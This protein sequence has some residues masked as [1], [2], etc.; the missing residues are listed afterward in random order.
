[1]AF[2]HD[3]LAR[4]RP[5]IFHLTARINLSRIRRLRKLES[6]TQLAKQAGRTEVLSERR[7]LHERLIID[8]EPVTLRDQAPLHKGN[9][10]LEASW[11]FDEFLRYLNGRVFFWPGTSSG[12]VIS[13]RRHFARYNAESPV[14]LR[15][16]FADLLVA[17]PGTTPEFCRFNSGS[18]RWHSGN[19]APRGPSTFV[20]ATA[21]TFRAS[22]VVE[23]TVPGE[24]QLPTA[25]F[26]GRHP[27]GP[28]RP[29]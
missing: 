2:T 4:L 21:A 7:R 22:Q 29:L 11:T 8:G 13:G 24:V 27:H 6:A 25:V 3:E 18:P 15:L 1:M 19:P 9:M 5:Y 26:V 20:N 16:S 28:W 17:N 23:I 10:K 14:I 12:P